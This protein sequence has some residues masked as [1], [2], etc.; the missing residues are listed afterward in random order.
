MNS[1]AWLRRADTALLAEVNAHECSTIRAHYWLVAVHV[2]Q[3]YLL[4][5]RRATDFGKLNFMRV[6]EPER[7]F[8]TIRTRAPPLAC[9]AEEL[10]IREEVMAFLMFY[11][12]P[13]VFSKHQLIAWHEVHPEWTYFS[14]SD[15]VFEYFSVFKVALGLVKTL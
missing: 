14:I 5:A 3:R 7:V 10:R 11:L 4:L 2:A 8:V 13:V 15:F 6:L 9:L 1:R 12:D